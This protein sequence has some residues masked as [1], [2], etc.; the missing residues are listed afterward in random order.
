[1]REYDASVILEKNSVVWSLGSIDITSVIV[2]RVDQA[3]MNTNISP[4]S[5]LEN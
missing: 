3:F 2:E 4:E 1:M 5:E